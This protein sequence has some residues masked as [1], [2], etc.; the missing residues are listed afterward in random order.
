ML[1]SAFWAGAGLI[2]LFWGLLRDE[3]SRR[4]GG[5][6]LLSLALAKVFLYDLAALESIYRVVSFVALGVLLLV[7][8]FAYQRIRPSVTAH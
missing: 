4:V 1:L 5:L 8:A 2:A 6:T 7:A 3:R